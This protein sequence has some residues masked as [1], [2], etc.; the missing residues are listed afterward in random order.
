MVKKIHWMEVLIVI[1]DGAG[2]RRQFPQATSNFKMVTKEM[3]WSHH[4]EEIMKQLQAVEKT[5]EI[6]LIHGKR[7]DK[8]W[9]DFIVC[10][11]SFANKLDNINP[12][13]GKTIYEPIIDKLNQIW[14]YAEKQVLTKSYVTIIYTDQG[15]GSYY[16]SGKGDHLQAKTNQNGVTWFKDDKTNLPKDL[17]F[18]F[19]E[20]DLKTTSHE[21]GHV[22]AK[23]GDKKENGNIMSG[24]IST[25]ERTATDSQKRRFYESKYVRT[26][27]I[28]KISKIQDYKAF[29]TIPPI[30]P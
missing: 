13:P 26:D 30:L 14:A 21:L 22:V 19:S 9:R 2:K 7:V 16:S 5:W 11:K 20:A 6:K 10:G 25:T 24:P 4:Q 12:I 8:Y 17:C 28:D 3:I 18:I 29:L 23:L 15:Q 27:S 1:I